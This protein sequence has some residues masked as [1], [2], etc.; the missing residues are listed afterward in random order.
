MHRS[1]R[2]RRSPMR[3]RGDRRDV[4]RS[5]AMAALRLPP[6]LFGQDQSVC[7]RVRVRRRRGDLHP[8]RFLQRS[9]RRLFP[10]RDVLAERYRA[11]VRLQRRARRRWARLLPH[12]LCGPE[13]GVRRHHQARRSR[14]AGREPKLPGWK[15]D[16]VPREPRRDG[17]AVQ[18]PRRKY[19]RVH[20][21]ELQQHGEHGHDQHLARDSERHVRRRIVDLV[22]HTKPQ[23][24]D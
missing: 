15:H 3:R 22:L 9:E 21:R 11:G 10:K 24:S 8:D 18:R 6:G 7:L 17:W 2:A 16:L 12:A 1:V 14:L 20:R 13:R 5:W 23:R 19:G 4:R